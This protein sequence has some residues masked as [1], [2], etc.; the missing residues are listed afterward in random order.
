M[1]EGQA[2]QQQQRGLEGEEKQQQQQEQQQLQGRKPAGLTTAA[3]G[4]GV[5]VNY[6]GEADLAIFH[7]SVNLLSSLLAALVRS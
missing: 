6:V 5:P 4:A 3:A 7:D 2:Q 1:Q